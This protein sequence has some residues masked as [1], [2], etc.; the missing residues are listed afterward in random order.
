[1]PNE[2]MQLDK[3]GVSNMTENEKLIS[4]YKN[5][6]ERVNGYAPHDVYYSRGYFYVQASASISK[7][8]YRRGQLER[9]ATAL[10]QRPSK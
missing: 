6:F 7:T 1:M 3:N 4:H 10:S 8:P 2:L 5:E 9:A